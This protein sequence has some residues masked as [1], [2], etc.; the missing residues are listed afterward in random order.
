[1]TDS[2]AD[3]QPAAAAAP[4]AAKEVDADKKTRKKRDF[5]TSGMSL[6]KR[7]APKPVPEAKP[8]EWVDD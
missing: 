5:G 4:A 6:R 8:V 7:E 1:M 3:E 2:K